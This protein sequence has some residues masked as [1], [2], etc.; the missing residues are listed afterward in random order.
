[1]EVAIQANIGLKVYEWSFMKQQ[2]DY[3]ITK[4]N[5]SA[6]VDQLASDIY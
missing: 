6:V 2:Q 4:K 5:P 1:M 3:R